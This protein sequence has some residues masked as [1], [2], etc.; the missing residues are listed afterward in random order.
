MTSSYPAR[1]TALVPAATSPGA[2]TGQHITR[3]LTPGLLLIVPRPGTP[4]PGH[5]GQPAPP[6]CPEDRSGMWLRNAAAGL[7]VL[8][9]ATTWTLWNWTWVEASIRRRVFRQR[10]VRAS[11]PAADRIR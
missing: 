11:G 1:I 7:C 10:A 8:A 5:G 4:P 3:P 2:G 6:R 9:A